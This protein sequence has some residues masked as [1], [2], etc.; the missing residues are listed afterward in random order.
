MKRD[1]VVFFYGDEVTVASGFYRSIPGKI[2]DIKWSLFRT[3]ILYK[4]EMQGDMWGY[5]LWLRALQIKMRK[6]R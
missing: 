3:R 1:T 4:V 5:H 6:P 2:V